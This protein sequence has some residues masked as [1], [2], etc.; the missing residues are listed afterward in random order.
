[1]AY[2]PCTL[3]IQRQD[4]S[5]AFSGQNRKEAQTQVSL[6]SLNDTGCVYEDIISLEPGFMK[7]VCLFYVIPGWQ[8]RAMR[9]K[10]GREIK[11]LCCS[12]LRIDP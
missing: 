1:L 3:Y 8:H 4:A 9:V 10:Q 11:L 2:F 6:L 12:H 7:L 5:E